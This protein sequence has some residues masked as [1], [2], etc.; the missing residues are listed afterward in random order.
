MRFF[1]Y[2]TQMQGGCNPVAVALHRVLQ[3]GRPAEIRGSLH[4]LAGTAPPFVAQDFLPSFALPNCVF[5]ATVPYSILRSKG[6]DVGKFD[7][8]GQLRMKA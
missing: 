8:V 6:A 7:F 2:G 5:H 1:Q 4:D 3:P